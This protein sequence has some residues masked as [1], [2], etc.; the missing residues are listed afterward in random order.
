MKRERRMNPKYQLVFGWRLQCAS[1][2][3]ALRATGYLLGTVA[4]ERMPKQALA[5][6]SGT[7]PAGIVRWS[8]AGTTELK[9]IS[10]AQVFIRG[11]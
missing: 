8:G 5:G 10:A 11:H 1:T 9:C 6:G 4:V 3:C 7:R 2:S